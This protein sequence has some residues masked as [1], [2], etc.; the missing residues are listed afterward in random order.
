MLE[1][2]HWVIYINVYISVKNNRKRT[3]NL[4]KEEA[5]NTVIENLLMHFLEK[6]KDSFLSQILTIKLLDKQ[7]DCLLFKSSYF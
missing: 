2:P 3:V 6:V 4:R 7:R 1:I 5:P